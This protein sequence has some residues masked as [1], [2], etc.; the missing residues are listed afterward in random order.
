ME[1][2]GSFSFTVPELHGD[3]AA[4]AQWGYGDNI[5]FAGLAPERGIAGDSPG[6]SLPWG[7]VSCRAGKVMGNREHPSRVKRAELCSLTLGV[8]AAMA[9]FRMEFLLPR[10]KRRGVRATKLPWWA[11]WGAQTAEHR[12]THPWSNGGLLIMAEEGTEWRAVPAQPAGE[13]APR[14]RVQEWSHPNPGA[15]A[16]M[17]QDPS[18]SLGFA[19]LLSHPGEKQGASLW[20]QREETHS[21]RTVGW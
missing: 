9:S 15:V 8:P 4:P 3:P 12:A 2:A 10:E 11:V 1:P 17:M 16:G 6:R 19:Q 7:T 14:S 13:N 20:G 5:P 21:K 18:L